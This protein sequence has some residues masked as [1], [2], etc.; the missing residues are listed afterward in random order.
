MTKKHFI[1]FADMLRQWR[2]ICSPATW[3]ELRDDIA[4]TLGRYNGRF[5][6]GRF[7]TWTEKDKTP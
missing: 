7:D 6:R 2:K 1:A 4:E 5:D 3:R